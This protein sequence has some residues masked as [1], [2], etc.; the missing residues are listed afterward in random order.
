MNGPQGHKITSVSIRGSFHIPLSHVGQK[1]ISGNRPCVNNTWV[2]SFQRDKS[3]RRALYPPRY[4]SPVACRRISLGQNGDSIVLLV[5][6]GLISQAFRPYH[7][8]WQQ[9]FLLPQHI[10]HNGEVRKPC[11]VPESQVT[12]GAIGQTCVD[13]KRQP[14]SIG[15]ASLWLS[16]R[17]LS[18]QK[19]CTHLCSFVLC[20]AC[21]IQSILVKGAT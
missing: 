15:E 12:V 9:W 7:K 19:S 16:K 14:P 13:F 11:S 4:S 2:A 3:A 20:I 21:V 8:V 1:A 10:S 18:V 17:F 6:G 5:C